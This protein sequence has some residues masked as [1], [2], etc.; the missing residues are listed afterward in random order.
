LAVLRF[1]TISNLVG[2]CTGRL[3]ITYVLGHATGCR[4]GKPRG[5]STG[6]FGVPAGRQSG[7]GALEQGEADRSHQGRPGRRPGALRRGPGRPGSP[8][9]PWIEGQ[10]PTPARHARGTAPLIRS[11][12]WRAA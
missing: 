10:V 5:N 8:G 1:R 2:S 4:R 11:P 3:S 7:P 6:R 12:R 9:G